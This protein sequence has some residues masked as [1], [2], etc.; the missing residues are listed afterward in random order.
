[1]FSGRFILFALILAALAL[2]ISFQQ[3]T[4]QSALL[5]SSLKSTDYSWQLFNSTTWQFD[6][7]QSKQNTITQADSVFYQ[8]AN[9]TSQLSQPRIVISQPEQTL[10]IRSQQGKTR[11]DSVLELSG[12][13]IITQFDQPYLTIKTD[14]QNKTL[15]TEFITYNSNT[16]EI[17]SRREVVITQANGTTSGTG[18]KANLKTRE[19]QLLSNVK[20][21][22]MPSTEN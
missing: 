2:W 22:Y 21:H 6:K 1:M 20:G 13:V 11:A 9:Q 8:E 17:N 7:T 14:S 10:V 15:T 12:Q 18:L 5:D 19:F 16:E 3:S 4:Q